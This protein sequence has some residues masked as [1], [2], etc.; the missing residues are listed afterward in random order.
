MKKIYVNTIFI[1]LLFASLFWGCTSK[2]YRFTATQENG[3]VAVK[4]ELLEGKA[5]SQKEMELNVK[6]L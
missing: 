2:F 1:F 5:L 3:E 6:V 4:T